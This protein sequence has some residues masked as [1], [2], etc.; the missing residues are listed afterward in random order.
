MMYTFPNHEF[1]KEIILQ[2]IYARLSH[3]NQTM[4]DSSSTGS[5]M[6]KTIEFR[7]DLFESIKCN[8]EDW[9]LD[10]CNESGIT[11]KFGYRCLSQVQ[12]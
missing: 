12:H 2:K 1:S 4:P 3:D 10:R 7:W 11:L 5:F 6:K 9:E 8:S